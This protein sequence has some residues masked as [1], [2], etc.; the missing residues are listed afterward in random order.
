LRGWPI[1]VAG[2]AV[3]AVAGRPPSAVAADCPCFDE[4]ALVKRVMP[5]VVNIKVTI[6]AKAITKTT[7]V[8]VQPPESDTLVGSGFIIDAGGLIVTNRHVIEGARR[9]LVTFYDGRVLR[10]SVVAMGSLADLAV[11]RVDAKAPLP[12]VEFGDSDAVAI[13]EPV[14]AIGDPLGFGGTVTSG[15]VSAL[16]RNIRSSPFDDFIQTDAAINH[17]NSGG[18]LFDLSGHVI[19][20]NTAL[21][22]PTTGSIGLGFSMPS[23]DVRIIAKL[24]IDGKRMPGWLGLSLQPVAALIAAAFGL[25]PERGA[26][27]AS[28][29][30]GGPGARAGVQP[31][32][33]IVAFNSEPVS[34]VREALKLAAI[35]EVGSVVTLTVR[36]N[37]ADQQ[38]PV[39]LGSWPEPVVQRGSRTQMAANP[40]VVPD[41]GLDLA[42]P[43]KAL[44]SRYRLPSNAD[45]V[46][47]TG[48]DTD[49]AAG[50]ADLRV[51]D[52][53]SHVQDTPVTTPNQLLGMLRAARTDG[54][55][56]VALLVQRQDQ[57]LWVGMSLNGNR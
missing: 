14:L 30:P 26:I 46:I 1:A 24:L 27:V 19:G 18:P 2:L 21:E 36:R 13:G 40:A 29:I 25:P 11:I 9:I 34:D 39:T 53:V 52:M 44:R 3:V 7:S 41:F 10:A 55:M 20:M 6:P 50:D 23:N 17:G 8:A 45:G 4:A 31:G 38:I 37:G 54:K 32:D 56:A 35:K 57:V 22:S 49:G 43:T 51:G 16:N 42:R 28:V 47:I 33:V 48:L 5:T 15:I 12:T